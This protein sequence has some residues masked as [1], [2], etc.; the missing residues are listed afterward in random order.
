[1]IWLEV[2]YS[3]ETQTVPSGVRYALRAE[4]INASG[5]PPEVFVYRTIDD[6]FMHVA[7]AYDLNV[8]PASK[9]SALAQQA[10]FYRVSAAPLVYETSA[11]SA[12][13]L[14][15]LKARLRLLV[16]QW[17]AAQTEALG[18]AEVEVYTAE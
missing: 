17:K 9:A 7:M 12:K 15:F 8:Y 1:M 3:P 5:V 6:V 2:R 11:A 16:T 10:D 4:V 13:A 14:R 18:D